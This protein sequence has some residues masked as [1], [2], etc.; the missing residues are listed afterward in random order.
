M[1]LPPGRNIR[2]GTCSWTEKTPLESGDFYP[3]GVDS[4]E[5]RLRFYAAHFDTVEV[6]STY[7]AI[8]GTKTTQLWAERTPPGFLFHIKAYGA[9]T[10]HGIAPK[11]LPI[12][13]R[14]LL[15]AE[16]RNK[17]R[18]YPSEEL[19]TAIADVFL[20]SLEPLKE[21]GKLGALVYQYPPWFWY[22]AANLDTVL[23]NKE[24]TSA[25]PMAVE[26][27]HGS[28]LSEN[29]R[30]QV[31]KLLRENGI[32]YITADEP[33]YGTLITVPFLPEATTDIAYLRLHGRNKATW[34]V[35][36]IEASVRYAYLYK[37][38]ELQHFIETARELSHKARMVFVMFNNCH[39]GYAVKNALELLQMMQ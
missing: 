18:I 15:P 21:A 9:L 19:L 26:F 32:A 27:R 10:G 6:D 37:A 24:R 12:I 16:E 35:K 28:W 1:A 17:E 23:R 14:E 11:R 20:A 3:K 33:Q 25:Y 5:E 8:P 36:G 34:L 30:D 31:F 22:K 39:L 29:H 4:A 13:L 38:P 7:Y 2:V